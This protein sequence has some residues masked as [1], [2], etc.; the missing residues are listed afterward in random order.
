MSLSTR[1]GLAALSTAAVLGTAGV[2]VAIAGENAPGQRIETQPVTE[3]STGTAAPSADPVSGT[4]A[5]GLDAHLTTV[6]DAAI[7]RTG[8]VAQRYEAA[9][10]QAREAA[11]RR[12]AAE[13]EAARAAKAARTAED[14]ERRAAA[15]Q[16]IPVTQVPSATDDTDD[17]RDA[18]PNRAGKHKKDRDD[19]GWGRDRRAGDRDDRGRHRGWDR[20]HGH[21]DDDRHHEGRHRADRD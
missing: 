21:D 13:R 18:T 10:A 20:G 4:Q 2:T 16:P 1:G 6:L 7:N 12:A 3:S 19:R 9:V 15:S 17:D 8:Q 5:A 14:A 11:A